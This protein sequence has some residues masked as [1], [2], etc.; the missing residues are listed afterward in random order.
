[1]KRKIGES[2]EH[3]RHQR[4][5]A[6]SLGLLFLTDLAILRANA[7][8]AL[9]NPC[10]YCG[11]RVTPKNISLDHQIPLAR[12]GSPD[13]WVFVC[14]LCNDRKGSLTQSEFAELIRVIGGWEPEARTD[15]LRRLRAGSKALR[16][17]YFKMNSK[18][19]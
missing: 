13:T 2:K 15:V 1:V 5:R 14:N 17:M 10:L 9:G 18:E 3:F 6:K 8:G 7:I 12:G 19:K 11:D 4:E 16:G